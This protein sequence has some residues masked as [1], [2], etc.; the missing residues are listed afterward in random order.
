MRPLQLKEVTDGTLFTEGQ[1]GNKFFIVEDGEC[2]VINRQGDV[3]K[4]LRSGESFA[5]NSFIFLVPHSATLRASKNT[6]L[7]FIDRDTFARE[8]LPRSERLQNVFSQFASIEV[9]E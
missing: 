8:V 7:W 2:Q 4:T 9:I 5:E 6:K 3:V 1:P